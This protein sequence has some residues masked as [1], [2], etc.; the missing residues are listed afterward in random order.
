MTAEQRIETLE[1]ALGDALTMH[2]MFECED[3]RDHAVGLKA[4]LDEARAVQSNLSALSSLQPGDRIDVCN[5][6]PHLGQII[7]VCESRTTKRM[8]AEFDGGPCVPWAFIL[9]ILRAA[10]HSPSFRIVRGGVA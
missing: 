5:E 10:A 1:S 3:T 2:S 7:H 4:M 6:G 9:P 8:Y